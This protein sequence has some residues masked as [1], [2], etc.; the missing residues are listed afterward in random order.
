MHHREGETLGSN[1][2]ARRS[3]LMSQV[4]LMYRVLLASVWQAMHLHQGYG[5][6]VMP[7][8]QQQL[9]YQ[10][11]Q[12]SLSRNNFHVSGLGPPCQH[13]NLSLV[14]LTYVAS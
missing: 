10:P 7:A 4:P 9:C 14:W 1:G 6:L 2:A 11:Y 3:T 13:L 8:P 5:F 12:Q